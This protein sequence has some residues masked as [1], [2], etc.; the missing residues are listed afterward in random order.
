MVG[1]CYGRLLAAMADLTVALWGSR[2]GLDGFDEWMGTGVALQA[3]KG[4]GAG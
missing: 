3:S 1:A 4:Q 2:G